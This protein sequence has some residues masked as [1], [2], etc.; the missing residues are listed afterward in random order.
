VLQRLPNENQVARLS[1]L[2][3]TAEKVL[4][5]FSQYFNS[6]A[7]LLAMQSDVLATAIPSVRLSVRPSVIRWY[8]T[9]MN[10]DRITR[11]SL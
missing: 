2:G 9:Q 7:A 4:D 3:K 5:I 11:T 6:A 8:C 1:S 10:E